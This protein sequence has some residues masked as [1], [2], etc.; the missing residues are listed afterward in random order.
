MMN[1]K[2]MVINFI[3]KYGNPMLNNLLK[4]DEESL[5]KFADNYCKERG[6]DYRTALNAFKNRMR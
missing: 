3:N 1:P 6:I 5:D 2:Q 4:M